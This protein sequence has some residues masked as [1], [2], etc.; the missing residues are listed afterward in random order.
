MF[1]WLFFWRTRQ[2]PPPEPPKLLPEPPTEGL[3]SMTT[4]KEAILA[5]KDTRSLA[6]VHSLSERLREKQSAHKRELQAVSTLT[7]QLAT[8][9]AALPMEDKTQDVKLLP[10]SDSSRLEALDKKRLA[11]FTRGCYAVPRLRA[12]R[13]IAPR[14]PQRSEHRRSLT[15]IAERDSEDTPA[16]NSNGQWPSTRK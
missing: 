7:V 14:F 16:V 11:Y 15:Q 10:T 1:Q 2:S 9:T 4:P 8:S 6:V 13:L 3:E 12:A 5:A